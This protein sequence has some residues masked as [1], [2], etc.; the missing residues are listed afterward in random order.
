MTGS[1]SSWFESNSFW[2][3]MFPFMFPEASFAS[4]T[5]NVPKLAA[6][7]GISTG[8][9]LDLACGPGR[10][11]VPLAQ[12]GFAVTGVDR[13]RFLLDKARDRA[14]SSGVNV[15]WVEADMRQF[16]RPAAFDLAINVFTSFGYFDDPAENRRVLENVLVSLKPGGTFLLDH[17]GKELLAA[18]FQPTRSD[19]LP[20]GTVLVQRMSVIDDWSRIE[21]EWM[22][23]EGDRVWKFF[24]RHW[25]YSG[26]E[27]RELLDS[28]GFTDVSLYGSLDGTPYDP[29]AVRL[30][31]LARK[32]A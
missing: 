31:A 14:K 28:V 6:L 27:M 1:E 3:R 19:S 21:G 13:T 26:R 9:V 10:Y 11:A 24:L 30:I 4:A 20:D 22:L 17:L 25:L 15:E 8:S 23:L 18:R 32:P 12:A 16:V 5:E 29:Q 2:T 7:T